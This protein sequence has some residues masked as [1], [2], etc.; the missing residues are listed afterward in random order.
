MAKLNSTTIQ[1]VTNKMS[2]SVSSSTNDK[3]YFEE[4]YNWSPQMAGEDIFAETVPHA[5]NPSEADTNVTNNPTILEKLVDYD[6]TELPASNGQGFGIFATPGDT[7]SERYKHFILPQKYG[8]GYGFTLKDSSGTVIPLTS[9]SYQFDYNNGILRFNDSNTPSSMG[10]STPLKITV[11]R[12]IGQTFSGGGTSN[13]FRPPVTLL[14]SVNNSKIT[15][16][17][18]QIDGVTVSD[19]DTVLFTNLTGGEVGDNNKVFTASVS[20]TSITW[21]L[22][23]D[24]ISG[25]G[26][27]TPGEQLMILKGMVGENQEYGFNGTTWVSIS[28]GSGSGNLTVEEADGNP[29]GNN[30]DKIS[31]AGGVSVYIDGTTAYLHAPPAPNPLTGTDLTTTSSF[32]TGR[33]SDG[34]VNYSG[35]EPAGSLVSYILNTPNATMTITHDPSTYQSGDTSL[36]KVIL[37]GTDIS[38][39]DNDSNFEEVNR[40]GCQT[41]SNYDNQGTGDP[42][43]DGVVDFVGGAS[44]YGSL[45]INSVCWTGNIPA[46]PYQQGTAQIN[47]TNASLWRQGYNEIVL[48]H[49]GSQTNPLKVFYD[50]DSGPDPS[51]SGQDLSLNTSVIKNLSGV[52]YYDTGTIFY[53]SAT[54]NDAFDNVYHSSGAPVV[55]GGFPG[56]SSVDLMYNDPTVSGVS[57]PPMIGETMTITNYQFTVQPNTQSSDVV[58][59][60]TPRDPYGNYT[61]VNTPSHNFTINSMTSNSTTTIE[62]FRD[63][64][65]RF[66]SDTD[67]NSVPGS[68]TGNWDSTIL[69]SSSTSGYDDGLQVYYENG[70]PTTRLRFPQDDFSTGRDPIGPDYSGIANTTRN[71]YRVFQSTIDNTN[72]ILA[73]PGL[74]DSDLTSGDVKIYIKVP[75]KTMWLDVWVDY[76]SGTFGTNATYP[77]GTD[78]EGCRINKTVHSPDIDGTIEFTL[79]TFASDSSV[80]RTLFVR[81]EYSDNSTAN[82]INGFGITN[83]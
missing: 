82:L 18:T 4:L 50:N 37:N 31:V 25:D 58:V 19:G 69:L 15:D 11:Y 57:D 21:T 41:I 36:T 23:T 12:Y 35:S 53:L 27:P 5:D 75:S 20:G 76:N 79:G 3:N 7:S 6:L 46:S 30:I 72:G 14:D 52:P 43:T 65:Y 34:N 62:N 51:V 48:E 28:G 77:S 71:Y 56:V 64:N 66:P 40:N 24:G 13:S 63:E 73:V 81:V 49:N 61:T 80:N 29:S 1:D 67:F 83:W 17:S 39:L 32:F 33:L 16:T 2:L 54:V 22:R 45:Q 55:I 68:L 47:I 44:G 9:G 38:T 42:V 59:N 70:T 8:N 26:S 74:S 60:L 10:W 78:G